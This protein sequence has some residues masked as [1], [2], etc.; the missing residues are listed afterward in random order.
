MML[1]EEYSGKRA[2]NAKRKGNAQIFKKIFLM[3]LPCTIDFMF[4]YITKKNIFVAFKLI[5]FYRNINK[6]SI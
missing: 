1:G 5:Y 4:G 3:I 6:L 2:P